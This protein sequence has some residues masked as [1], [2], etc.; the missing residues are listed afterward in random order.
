LSTHL[1]D[2]LE[3][4]QKII[5]KLAED[6]GNGK[7]IVVEGKKDEKALKDLGVNGAIVTVKTGGKSFLE[8]IAEIESLG[9]N[10]VILLL[11][12]DR[13]GKEGTKRLQ[14]NLERA[15]IKVNLRFWREIHGLVGREVQC[16]ESLAS[17]LGT[18]SK[19]ASNQQ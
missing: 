6:S 12:F 10:E 18:I 15:N 19:K 9:A 7:P 3:K 4:I 11:D 1:Q 17:Y 5:T 16:I 13:R 2:R 8:A 14:E